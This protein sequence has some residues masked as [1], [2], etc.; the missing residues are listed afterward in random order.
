MYQ[1]LNSTVP[2]SGNFATASVKYRKS[3]RL[4]INTKPIKV[5]TVL[6]KF[7]LN[8]QIVQTARSVVQ[9]Q[10]YVG[11]EQ[12]N[13]GSGILISLNGRKA[14][15][16]TNQHVVRYYP[17]TDNYKIQIFDPSR[18]SL[19]NFDAS[20]FLDDAQHDIALLEIHIDD[21]ALL[22]ELRPLK[23]ATEDEKQGQVTHFL[24]FQKDV[25]TYI[26]GIVHSPPI[27]STYGIPLKQNY[28]TVLEDWT[29][30]KDPASVFQIA[31][32]YEG[33]VT[34]RQIAEENIRQTGSQKDN[35]DGLYWSNILNPKGYLGILKGDENDLRRM[36]GGFM[37]NNSG[38]ILGINE[39]GFSKTK[40][41][42][43]IAY[44]LKL[45]TGNLG[46]HTSLY[47]GSIGN[48]E[49]LSF[50]VDHNVEFES[51]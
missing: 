31:Y 5:A 2:Y 13:I 29:R 33:Q 6:E 1:V 8:S 28:A 12:A 4:K 34:F 10:S 41:A 43:A 47:L 38:E 50:L 11:Q 39:A 3:G 32:W 42:N 21:E 36:S 49:V 27:S 30:G 15:F 9:V 22:K 48:K 25:L 45:I 44:A 16:I 17:E 24:G 26:P 23:F 20:C 14:I 35:F 7:G 40:I 37:G 19:T 46:G 51:A 18:N